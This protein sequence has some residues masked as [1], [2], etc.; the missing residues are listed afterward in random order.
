MNKIYHRPA[1][2]SEQ[3]GSPAAPQIATYRRPRITL[4][5]SAVFG[6]LLVTF[7]LASGPLQYAVADQSGSAYF[8]AGAL[9]ALAVMGALLCAELRRARQL[10]R[11]G[12]EVDRVELGL[13]RARAVTAGEVTSAAGLRRV[14]WAGPLTLGAGAA[15]LAVAG[16]LLTIASGAGFSLLAATALF[17]A[18]GIATLALLEL[19]PAP[20]SP[21]SQLVFARAWRR[22]GQRDAAI[23]SAARAGVV[24]GWLLI[25]AGIALAVFVSFAGIWLAFIGGIAITGSRLTLA[26]ARAR[27]R[28][29]GLRAS[30]VM[31]PP[32]PVVSSFAT[33]GN[34]FTD[35]ALPSRAA[36]LIVRDP[37]GSFAGVVATKTLAAVPGDD[38]ETLRVRRLAMP[39]SAVPTATPDEPIEQVLESLARNPLSGLVAVLS[40]AGD[41]AVGEVVGIITPADVARTIEL[42]DAAHPAGRRSPTKFFPFG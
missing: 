41:G 25:A 38:R 2:S 12:V 35:V 23:L 42:M 33:A 13:L 17:T 27:Q 37:D 32:P 7:I 3:N 8:S 24:S 28:L 22:S 40:E 11:A 21:G 34:A 26:G 30:D 1:D 10:I 18:I 6:W 16:G 4:R 20:G 14:S 29:A 9:G 15:A 36:L 39:A 31:S 19:I 5:P